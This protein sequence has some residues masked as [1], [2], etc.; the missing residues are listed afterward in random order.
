M[1]PLTWPHRLDSVRGVL[2]YR[3]TWHVQ[4]VNYSGFAD[5]GDFYRRLYLCLQAEIQEVAA[6][7]S[8]AA[9]ATVRGGRRIPRR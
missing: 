7:A 4:A 2:P 9:E 6:A 1:E 5:R 3:G 8:L